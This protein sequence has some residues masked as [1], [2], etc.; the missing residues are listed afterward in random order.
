[1][2]NLQTVLFWLPFLAF[3]LSC[4]C[5][6]WLAHDLAKRGQVDLPVERSSH[7]MP[8]P[9][10]GGLA[11]VGSF[12]I[13]AA[14]MGLNP[15]LLIMLAVLAA[16][17]WLDDHRPLT[18]RVRLLT[19]CLAVGLSLAALWQADILSALYMYFPEMPLLF[20]V[21]ALGLAWLWHINLTNFMDGIDGYAA[22]QIL[23]I[24]FAGGIYILIFTDNQANALPIF[25]LGAA[26]LGFFVWN[27][28]PARIFLGEVGSIPLGFLSGFFLIKLAAEGGWGLAAAL[29]L[30]FW[31]DATFTLL[32]RLLRK[33]SPLEPHREHLYQRAAGWTPAGHRKVLHAFLLLQLLNC[34]GFVAIMRLAPQQWLLPVLSALIGAI[35]FSILKKFAADS[36]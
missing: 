8:I 14:I 12:V 25:T 31:L 22:A 20:F 29:P 5:T 2:L 17:S 23:V 4:L 11:I 32:R 36:V 1:M 19:Q 21:A 3:C 9:R 6:L 24:A 27:Y 13:C 26:T 35:Y 15:L 33:R 16:I 18:W 7:L 28:P 30:W 34:A 10:G